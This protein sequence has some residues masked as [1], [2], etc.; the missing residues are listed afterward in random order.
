M[1]A[2]VA[3]AILEIR[4]EARAEEG[5]ARVETGSFAV[6]A[7]S[8]HEA[9]EYEMRRRP[10]ALVPGPAP[11]PSGSARVPESES[12]TAAPGKDPAS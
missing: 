8:V 5:A 10:L 12:G 7:K 3:M 2:G 4:Q 11:T 9:E 6:S 1:L